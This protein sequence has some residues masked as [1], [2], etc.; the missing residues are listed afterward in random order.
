MP[1]ERNP[2][3]N[4]AQGEESPARLPIG[5]N[6]LPPGYEWGGSPDPERSD[7]AV[8]IEFELPNTGT[9]RVIGPKEIAFLAIMVLAIMGSVFLWTIS[10]I[11]GPM[12]T[13]LIA[14]AGWVTW[15]RL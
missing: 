15:K 11:G 12:A 7:P 6:G 2:A 9:I 4:G 13:A 1:D 14:A 3:D 8:F 5:N 10:I